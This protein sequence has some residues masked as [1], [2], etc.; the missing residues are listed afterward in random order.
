M[1]FQRSTMTSDEVPSPNTKRP[2]AASAIVATLMASVAGPLVNE[3]TMPVPS[4]SEGAHAAVIAS[5]TKPSVPLASADQ[6]SL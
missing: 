3:G 6:T 5:G 4:R 1:P 2:G